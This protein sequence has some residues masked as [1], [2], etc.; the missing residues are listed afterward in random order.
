MNDPVELSDS[1]NAFG[2]EDFGSNLGRSIEQLL[3][4][5]INPFDPNSF[6]PGNFWHD[7]PNP[8][9]H[10]SSIHD[11][12][13][14]QISTVIQQVQSDRVTR[15]IVLTGES[16][17]GKSHLLG[18]IK[19][20][21]NDR[22]FFVYVGP[23]PD[24]SFIWRHLLRN[25]VDSLLQK[26]EGS[27]DS[28][29]ML[30]LK[31]LLQL[32]SED[33]ARQ[34]FGKRRSFIR[35]LGT[36]YPTGIYNSNEF[37]G[38]LYDLTN[39][40]MAFIAASWLRGDNLDEES[41]LELRVKQPLDS[42]DAAQK[43]LANFGKIAVANRPIVL[44][45][46]NLDNLPHLPT[47]HPDFQSLFN[48]N[49]SIHN[50]KL[51]NLLILISIV[52][53]TWKQN[54]PLIQPADLA[55]V[56]Q[57]LV[58]RAITLEQAASLWETRLK[59]Y[60]LQCDPRPESPLAPLQF[61]CLEAEFP[62]GKTLPRRALMLG[63][64]LI[65]RLKQEGLAAIDTVAIDS[66][67]YSVSPDSNT[68]NTPNT[69]E[70]TISETP[71]AVSQISQTIADLHILWQQELQKVKQ[72]LT[73]ISQLSSPDLLWRLREVLELLQIPDLYSPL[74]EGTKF[75]SYSLAYGTIGLI[76]VEDSHQA[77]FYHLMKACQKL[78]A[79]KDWTGLYLLRAEPLGKRTSKAY[80]IYRRIF[81]YDHY[82]HIQPDLESVQQLETY[83]RLLNAASG[84]ELVVGRENPDVETLQNLLREAHLLDRCLLLKVLGLVSEAG[85]E[86][87]KEEQDRQQHREKYTEQN[88]RY[89]T[90]SNNHSV[91]DHSLVHALP[92]Q[93]KIPID[94]IAQEYLLHLLITQ[95]LMGLKVL[96]KQG[97]LQFPELTELQI[98][99]ILESLC[100][101]KQIYLLN[102]N[103][104]KVEQLVSCRPLS[105]SVS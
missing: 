39:P 48:V 76:W 72:T 83:H 79:R 35:T 53:D 65:D 16:G 92:K 28:Q 24:S 73:R 46:D 58:L 18:R 57:E 44:C 86:Q 42:E 33:F 50:D 2:S 34:I 101:A 52:T 69:P 94:H 30:W 93:T 74:L 20:L 6:K 80:Q 85:V 26:P 29:L 82:V 90:Y 68:P 66:P 49:S 21:F 61:Q 1:L 5:E 3:R 78:L 23:W 62:G 43:I 75:A 22:A 89:L 47:G 64:K 27:T 37:F 4:Q 99:A 100:Q 13:L 31:A 59:P 38:V 71:P 11:P 97:C 88:D 70:I 104:R 15:T 7:L 32:Q 17:A 14:T 60:H 95:Q 84:R 55:R 40:E 41:C 9:L 12:L 19:T 67:R 10:I 91:D 56:N 77:S 63:Q 25:T 102:P 51:Q 103:D 8:S 87:E 81:A 98:E 105:F 36:Q 54:R 96:I 45:F